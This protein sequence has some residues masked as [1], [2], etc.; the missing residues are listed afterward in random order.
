[1]F[2][3]SFSAQSMHCHLCSLGP[4]GL[5]IITLTAFRCFNSLLQS[6]QFMAII[7]SQVGRDGQH[8]LL[9]FFPLDTKRNLETTDGQEVKTANP[10][11][12][13]H[14][15]FSHSFTMFARHR[16]RIVEGSLT[17]EGHTLLSLLL[18]CHCVRHLT[19]TFFWRMILIRFGLFM[20]VIISFFL[21]AVN[22]S[23]VQPNP[24]NHPRHSY[25]KA[26]CP[27]HA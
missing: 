20:A 21:S 9:L 1:M 10:L 15:L 18:V 19:H 14:V 3:R 27:A 17:Q 5:G 2:F 23:S 16:V 11:C 6:M 26:Q 25:C 24:C 7:L 22:R 13:D 4:S 12:L 8:L